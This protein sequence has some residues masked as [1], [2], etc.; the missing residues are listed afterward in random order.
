MV[1][2]PHVAE[3]DV[4]QRGGQFSRRVEDLHDGELAAIVES[5]DGQVVSGRRMVGRA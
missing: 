3:T 4:G 2:H 5:T 1:V